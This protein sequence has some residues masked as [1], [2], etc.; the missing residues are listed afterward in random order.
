MRI[1]IYRH[2]IEKPWTYSR[3]DRYQRQIAE[4]LLADPNAEGKWII[5]ELAPVIT[6]GRRV[7]SSPT[8]LVPQ[9]QLSR[10]GI[11]IYPTDRGGL[12][13]YHGPGQWVFFLVDRLEKTHC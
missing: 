13:T 12:A 7:S 10:K 6:L 9:E 5:S 2:S 8:F 11:E 1:E 3:L 4:Q